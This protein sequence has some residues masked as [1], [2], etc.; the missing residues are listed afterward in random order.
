MEANCMPEKERPTISDLNQAIYKC[1]S[2]AYDKSMMHNIT[3]LAAV[4][5]DAAHNKDTLQKEDVERL[6]RGTL[7]FISR[8][9]PS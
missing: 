1:E 4:G 5:N 9:S 6:K 8:Y 3:A 2:I 7:E